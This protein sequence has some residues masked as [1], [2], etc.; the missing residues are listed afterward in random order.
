MLKPKD[1][2]TL[3]DSMVELFSQAEEDILADMAR[4][5]STYDYWIPAVE[6]QRKKLVEMGNFHS[7]ILKA[8][9][10]LTGKSETE[11]KW[12]MQEA[13]QK[14]LSFDRGIYEEHGLSPPPL[15]ASRPSRR[16]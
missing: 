15:A 11:L 3:P 7:F 13:G 12:L 8:L 1:L 9:S 10:A 6:H 16:C 14:A 2:D 4:R 5:I